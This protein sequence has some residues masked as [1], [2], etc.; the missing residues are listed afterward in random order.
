MSPILKACLL[1]LPFLV[2]CRNEP[3][4]PL[5]AEQKD[6]RELLRQ[7]RED[8]KP[9]SSARKLSIQLL[10]ERDKIR[11][12][13]PLGYR[14][15]MQN[16]GREP[17]PVKED[18]PSFVKDGSLCGLSAFRLYATPPKGKERLLP[19]RSEDAAEV[20]PSTAPARRPPSGLDV[21]LLPGEYLLTRGS[22]P[23]KPFRPLETALAFEALGTYR[24]KVVYEKDG[25]KA[26]SNTVR[27]EV[28]P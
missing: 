18:A 9:G 21:T 24:L 3:P 11:K 23:G 22:G 20:R 17:L 4:P 2:S 12:G 14:L 5:T 13:E 19:C 1:L 28:V 8:W 10:A 6:R 7:P 26:V 16:A 27:V 25:F 15:E